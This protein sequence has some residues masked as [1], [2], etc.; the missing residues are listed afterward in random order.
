MLICVALVC[1][2]LINTTFA[3][4]PNYNLVLPIPV[5]S[6]GAS[7]SSIEAAIDQLVQ[8]AVENEKIP[9]ITIA[10][11]KNGRL[12][13]SKAYGYSDFPAKKAMQPYTRSKIGSVS[14]VLTGLGVMKLTEE[15]PTF[16]LNKKVYGGYGVFKDWQDYDINNAKGPARWYAQIEMRH[17]LSHTSGFIGGGSIEEAA[18]LFEVEDDEDVTYKQIHQHFIK[19]VG[20]KYEPGTDAEYS[21]H[22]IGL[23]GHILSE[24]SGV[25]YHTYI[26]NKILKPLS[27]ESRVV[28]YSINTTAA[29]MSALHSLD[30]NGNIIKT[31]HVPT[32]KV[33]QGLAAGGWAAAAQDMVRVMLATDNLPNYPDLLKPATLTLME[34]RPFPN[35]SSRGVVWSV[36]PRGAGKKLTHNG[37]TEGGRAVIIKFTPGYKA[38]DNTDLSNIN[39]AACANGAVST[40]KLDALLGEIAKIVGKANIPATYDLFLSKITMP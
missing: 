7:H 40:N 30:G 2:L 6:S 19:T 16:T 22:G 26:T 31:P 3:Q 23:C 8:D 34:T 5:P 36:N 24:V 18:D 10:V 4:G 1:K 35:V 12:V 14:K 28:P 17:L 20:I 38:I 21:N 37:K 25:P 32:E 33:S 11:S 29:N 39:L 27:L 15:N 9:G 13:F